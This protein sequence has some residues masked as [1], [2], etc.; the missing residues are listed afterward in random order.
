MGKRHSHTSHLIPTGKRYV[1][2]KR[3]IVEEPCELKGSSTVLKTN[4][5]GDN[6]VEFNYLGKLAQF[7]KDY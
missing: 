2:E 3:Q 1:I 7:I 5:V 4:K 6:L